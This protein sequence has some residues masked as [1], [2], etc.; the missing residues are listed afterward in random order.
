MS[1][2]YKLFG[3]E[4]SYDYS[5]QSLQEC[6]ESESLGERIDISQTNNGYIIGKHWMDVTVKMWR[7]D[8]QQGILF[9][10]EL[11]EYEKFKDYHWWLD[12]VLKDCNRE[13]ENNIRL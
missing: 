7:Q 11:Y 8:I 13:C 4:S 9:K 6:F 5:G 2:I 12:R 1:N 10:F 3:Y